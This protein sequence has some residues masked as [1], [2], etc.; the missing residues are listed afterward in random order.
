MIHRHAEFQAIPS[1]RSPTYAQKPLRTDGQTDR[2][3]D[4]HVVKWSRMVG[5]TNGPMYRWKEGISGFRQLEN[6][7]PPAL[8][9]GGIK[10]PASLPNVRLRNAKPIPHISIKA[11]YTWNIQILLAINS[12][13]LCQVSLSVAMWDILIYFIYIGWNEKRYATTRGLIQYNN[14]VLLV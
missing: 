13:H 10:I 5:W 8:K 12:V 4:R 9:G 1:M 11:H 2:L 7:M 6:I 3:M 14:A